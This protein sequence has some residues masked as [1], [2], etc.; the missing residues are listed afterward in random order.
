MERLS[1]RL[2]L[3]VGLLAVP[4]CQASPPVSLKLDSVSV[5]AL[6]GA[7]ATEVIAEDEISEGLWQE[8]ELFLELDGIDCPW[9]ESVLGMKTRR[10]D[11]AEVKA[12]L[13]DRASHHAIYADGREDPRPVFA[14]TADSA[15]LRVGYRGASSDDVE[16]E[17]WCGTPGMLVNRRFV[18]R[19]NGASWQ[20]VRVLGTVYLMNCQG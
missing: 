11:G 2:V 8:E 20:L 18:L 7:I 13:R 17:A 15:I 12:F 19:R 3:V 9:P 16:L 4:C 14:V 5:A 6:V 1:K 10:Y